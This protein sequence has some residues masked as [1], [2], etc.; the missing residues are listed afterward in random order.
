MK[1]CNK[2]FEVKPL[3][4]FYTHPK[5]SD[6]HLGKCKECSKVLSRENRLANVKYYRD[7]DKFRFENDPRVLK[8]NQIYAKSDQG[9]LV[10]NILK[11]KWINKNPVARASHVILGNAVKYGKIDKPNNCS[12]CGNFT[13]SRKLHAHH[14]DYAKPL[15]VT[16]VCVQ[17]HTN[18]H[19]EVTQ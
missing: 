19:K 7:Y 13:P 3:V 5:S 4:D 12:C 10:N 2:C 15:D 8:R 1:K 16:W 11:K 18:I 6:G 17:C 14:H 9:K